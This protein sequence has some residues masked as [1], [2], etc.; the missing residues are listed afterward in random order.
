MRFPSTFNFVFCTLWLSGTWVQAEEKTAAERGYEAMT[1][2]TFAPALWS[3]KAYD[4]VWRI[5]GLDQKPEDFE[6][7]FMERYGL[8][9][10]P[11]DNKGLPMGLRRVSGLLGP[12]IT[13]DCL[14]CH[15]GSIAGQSVLGLGNASLDLQLLY[16]E[17]YAADGVGFRWP[18]RFSSVRGTVEAGALLGYL[19]E[20]RDTD[21]RI[22]K[23][24]VRL[25]FRDDLCEDVPAWWNLKKKSTMYHTG[26]VSTRS[27]RS[28][29]SFML[30]PLHTSDYIKKHEAVFADIRQWLLTLEPPRYP[31]E[32]DSELAVRGKEV[33][34]ENCVRCHGSYGP[35][36]H[37]PNKH[38]P[39]DVIGTDPTLAKGFT[40]EFLEHYSGSWF[41][42]EESEEGEPYIHYRE[43]YQAPPLDGVWATAPYFHN[44]SV[45]T[46]YHV[47]N[48]KS[49][50]KIYSRSFRTDQE[51]YDPLRL[52]WRIE[53]LAGTDDSCVTEMQR[54]K[55]YDTA[56]PGR[57]NG[58]HAF[59]DHLDEE[60]RF[61]VIEYLKTL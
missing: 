29:M 57:G 13:N 49:R 20:Y 56:Q 39:L 28:L 6:Q 1:R 50:P 48:S 7:R 17:M 23:K 8:H 27:V 32:I 42:R 47:L 34:Q 2:R 21:L 61:A 59:G 37:Y 5:W 10:A 41:G 55:I 45:P 14:V 43:V 51:D 9:P 4:H 60:E 33:F 18:F 44:G 53:E 46:V 38:L 19:M 58:G 52:G 36:G 15:A 3:A 54:H 40:S 30:S 26:G 24:P 35:D 25:G 31:F 11:F 12:G 22:L 16:S